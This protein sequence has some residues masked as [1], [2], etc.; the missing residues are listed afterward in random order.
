LVNV[1]LPLCDGHGRQVTF[2]IAEEFLHLCYRYGPGKVPGDWAD[3]NTRSRL[4][5]V[6][7]PAAFTLALD[8]VIEASGVTLFLDTRV[9]RPEVTDRRV[10][11]IE[12]ENA[13][14]RGRLSARCV[15]DATGDALIAMRAGAPHVDG[16]NWVTI[17]ALQ[18]GLER[19][20]A[21]A[22]VGKGATLLDRVIL[23]GGPDGANAA[24]ESP[25]PIPGIDANKNTRFAV[26]S[27]RLLRKHYGILH[28]RGGRTN[29]ENLFPVTLP[30][31]P[32]FRKI[33]AIRG[34]AAMDSGQ[35]DVQRSDSVGLVSDWRKPGPVWEVPYGALVPRDV[36]GVLVAGRCIAAVGDAWEVM[37]V[38]PAAALT[39]QVAGLAAAVCCENGFSPEELLYSLLA[40]RLR[41]AAIPTH[42]NE[43]KA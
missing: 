22:D 33:R 20:E 19:A 10:T 5:T 16:E 7:S 24:P 30:A 23:G 11:G 29:R 12:V 1:Y 18:A 43:L 36:Q 39:G 37:R 21:A 35:A 25:D 15:I 4:R 26:D 38:I 8:E 41:E 32:Q 17:W 13:D 2:G 42:V 28:A 40:E 14:G 9:C 3:P 6:F 34:M 27:R 31:M